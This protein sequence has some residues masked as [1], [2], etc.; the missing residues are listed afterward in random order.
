MHRVYPCISTYGMICMVG[1]LGLHAL[2]ASVLIPF[3]LR[4]VC[5]LFKA[6]ICFDYLFCRTWESKDHILNGFLEKTMNLVVIY[7]DQFQGTII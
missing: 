6:T 5:R 7:S 4:V 3:S 2:L 1:L